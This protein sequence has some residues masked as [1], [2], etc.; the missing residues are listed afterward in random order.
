MKENLHSLIYLAQCDTTTGFLSHNAEILNLC[1]SRP[2]EQPLLI[3]SSSLHT[4]KTLVRVPKKH[5]NRIRKAKY[6]TFIYPNKKALRLVREELHSH[7]LKEFK[8]LYS[9]SANPTKEDFNEIWAREKCD[10]IV[11]DKRGFSQKTPS[12]I[13]KINQHAIQRR[14]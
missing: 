7:F 3:E 11:L 2:K 5:K 6:A 12:R 1:K 8:T 4:L 10:V 9:T 14:R 13:Y